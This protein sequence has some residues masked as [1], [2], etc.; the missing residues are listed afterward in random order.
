MPWI[1]YETK[2]VIT[3]RVYV[4]V[5][6]QSSEGFDGYLGSGIAVNDAISRYGRK[7]FVRT[8]I[9]SFDTSDEAY[10]LES[11][12][13]TEAWCRSNKT[14]NLKIGGKGG[15]GVRHTLRSR[16]IMSMRR[17]GVP[18]DEATKQKIR[19]SLTGR[20]MS[21]KHRENLS[22]AMSI[23]NCGRVMTEETRKKLA[24]RQREAW[25]RGRKADGTMPL[26][27]SITKSIVESA[28]KRGW[29]TF[30][31]AGGPMQTSGMPDLLCLRHG[32]AVFLEV[33]RPGR[34]PTP[35]QD[36]RMREIREVGGAV[37]ECVT[38]RQEAEGVLDANNTRVA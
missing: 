14:Y 13:V 21:Q 8:T 26:E 35:L 29:W 3:G 10:S 17:R 31:I 34:K 20:K 1:V 12:I 24:D 37:A 32:R 38:S 33:K 6:K 15:I 28:R 18:K 22:R 16:A 30:K 23:A 9:A 7:N 25:R 36:Q 11:T 2:N 27:T 5:H 19:E 4:G